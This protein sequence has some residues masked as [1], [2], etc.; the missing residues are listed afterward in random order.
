MEMKGIKKRDVDKPEYA[1]WFCSTTFTLGCN[2]TASLRKENT[3]ILSYS[4]PKS[5]HRNKQTKTLI[6][7]VM[8]K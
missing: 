3:C 5:K 7:S 2:I 4:A 8:N 1:L 6:M